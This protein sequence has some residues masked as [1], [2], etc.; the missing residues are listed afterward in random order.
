MQKQANVKKTKILES[1]VNKERLSGV[2]LA[3][4]NLLTKLGSEIM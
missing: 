1:W 4:H 2:D 3:V